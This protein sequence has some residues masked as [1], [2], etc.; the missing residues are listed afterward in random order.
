M[1]QYILNTAPMDK[2]VAGQLSHVDAIVEPFKIAA[3]HG[4]TYG[5]PAKLDS[6]GNL[7]ALTANTDVVAAIIVREHLVAPRNFG[8]F[9]TDDFPAGPAVI[10][11][12]KEGYIVVAVDSTDTTFAYGTAVKYNKDTGKFGTTGGVTVRATFVSA[13][14]QADGLA[15]IDFRR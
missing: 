2:G 1:G 13:G 12:L 5:A 4:L 14:I 8:T 7:V 3:S 10:G 6:S 11:G 9:N 15:V